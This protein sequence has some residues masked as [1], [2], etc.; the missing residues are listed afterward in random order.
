MLSCKVLCS[1]R[2]PSLLYFEKSGG[3]YEKKKA[4]LCPLQV[5]DSYPYVLIPEPFPDQLRPAVNTLASFFV[6][7]PRQRF[8][9]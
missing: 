8:T 1:L 4:Y 7:S 2:R 9:R 6:A 3:N 5:L